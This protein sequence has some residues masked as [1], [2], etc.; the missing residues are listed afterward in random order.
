MVRNSNG[1]S[2]KV[3]ARKLEILRTAA[4]AFRTRGFDGA[5]MRDIA[6]ALGMTATALY[7][8]FRNKEEI[9]YFCQDHSLDR[10]LSEAG[11]IARQRAPADHRLRALIV[12]QMNCMLDELAGS[13]AHIDFH[14]LPDRLLRRV[15]AKRDRYESILCGVVA[16]GIRHGVFL[17]GDVKLRALAILGAINWSVRWYRPE[18]SKPPREIARIFADYLVQGLRR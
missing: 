9:L 4:S 6:R 7:Y 11:H 3:V 8:Y 10:L 14:A 16:E 5:G 2:K 17:P 15:I 18:G 1:R 13:A 12:A